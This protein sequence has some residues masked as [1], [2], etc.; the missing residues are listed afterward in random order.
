MAQNYQI[1]PQSGLPVLQTLGGQGIPLPLSAQQMQQAGAQLAPPPGIAAPAPPPS[2]GQLAANDFRVHLQDPNQID[3]AALQ[4]QSPKYIPLGAQPPGAD[5][6]RQKLDAPPALPDSK[7]LKVGW[8]PTPEEKAAEKKAGPKLAE[9]KPEEGAAA[10]SGGGLDDDKVIAAA[11]AGGGGGPALYGVTKEKRKF[12]VPGAVDPELSKDIKAGTEN[13]DKA[14]EARVEDH[15]TADHAYLTAEAAAQQAR[16]D[17]IAAERARREAVNAELQRLQNVRTQREQD[18][19]SLKAP[20]L[21]DYWKDKGMGAQIATAIAAV[22]GGWLQGYRGGSNPGIDLMNQNID[23]WVASQKEEYERARGKISDADNQYKEALSIYGSPA[24]A[25]ADL[26]LRSYAV[27][28]AQLLNAA[29][30]IGTDDAMKNA[31]LA[32]QQNQ[33]ARKQATAQAQQAASTEVEQDMGWQG[34]GAGGGVLGQLRRGAEAKKLLR[35]IKGGTPEDR[36][37]QVRLPSGGVGYVPAANGRKEVQEKIT[38][39]QDIITGLSELKKI[40]ADRGLTDMEKRG[41][42]QSLQ[43][44]LASKISIL[45]G[46]GVVTDGEREQLTKTLGDYNAILK[47]NGAILDTTQRQIQGVVD[48]VIRDNVYQDPDATRP[49]APPKSA[50]RSARDVDE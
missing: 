25:E 10:S 19:A 15:A 9:P 6:L 31:Q 13:L 8:G 50:P 33:L 41:K 16:A 22:C 47:D 49:Y 36:E 40:A 27:V 37:R 4:N 12:T 1:D 3:L 20:Q 14:Q 34:G 28:D 30:Q 39:G 5:S 32:I 24:Q 42:F 46:Q 38:N 18:A 7:D 35:D 21:E 45:N 26:R 44:T 43:T 48:G 23:R 29:K 17:D 11:M 2:P